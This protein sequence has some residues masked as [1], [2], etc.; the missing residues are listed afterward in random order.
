[1]NQLKKKPGCYCR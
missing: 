1:V